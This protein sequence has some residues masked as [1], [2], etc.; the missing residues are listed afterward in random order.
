MTDAI[1]AAFHEQAELC[2][3]VGSP[4]TGALLDSL[5]TILSAQTQSG[6]VI[7]AWTG[8]P[9]IAALPLRITGGLHA[10]AR[11]GQDDE[12]SALYATR[13]G[14]V[15]II[16]ARVLT[17]WD[18][19]LLPWLDSAPQTNEVGR[20]GMLW[21]GVMEVARRFGSRLSLLELGASA[22]LNL[23]MD[24]YQY[25]LGGVTAG[26]T[27]SPVH[28]RPD[29]IG[30]PPPA[31]EVRVESRRGVD[32]NP[33]DVRQPDI[34][35]RLLAYV[36]PD[37]PERL[38]RIAAAITIAQTHA[39]SIDRADG[40]DWIEARLAEPQEEG[41]TRLIYHSI[42]LQYFPAES[43]ARTINAI[44]AAG[45]KATPTRPLAWLSMEFAREVK[46]SALL[47][48]HCWPG[49]EEGAV[50]GQVHPHGATINWSGC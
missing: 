47:R 22:G 38:A 26:K 30:A 27:G 12:L 20:S 16:L 6:R 46:A 24:H 40:A 35:N 48:L 8:D 49:L 14:S 11:S 50:L 9:L 23:N 13:A 43:R 15:D 7:L 36:W 45:Q 25:E 21:P 18:A 29:W 2:R 4:F 17:Q 3:A 10:L 34:A 19:W 42:A 39:P 1:R 33:L 41:V 5:A 28:L 37:Q 44:R 31:A 32:L